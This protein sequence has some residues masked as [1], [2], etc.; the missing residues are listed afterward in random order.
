MTAFRDY[1]LR[2]VEQASAKRRCLLVAPMGAGKTAIA[3]GWA[4]KIAA[5]RTLILAPKRVARHT[6][7]SEAETWGADV[8]PAWGTADQ[9]ARAWDNAPP[10]SLIVSTHGVAGWWVDY[11]RGLGENDALILDESTAVKSSKSD[12]SRAIARL[13][14]RAGAV[15]AMTGSPTPGGLIDIWAQM[16]VVRPDLLGNK[17]AF[18]AEFFN[19]YQRPGIQWATYDPRPGACEAVAR[20]I[21]PAVITLRVQPADL[22]RVDVDLRVDLPSAVMRNYRQLARDGVVDE[23]T[24]SS[25]GVLSGKLRQYAQGRIYDDAR[26]IHEIHREK[27]NALGEVLDEADDNAIIAVAYRHDREIIARKH[28]TVDITATDAVK[29]WNARK[30]PALTMHPASG[31]HGLNL[32]SG[33]SIIIWYGLPWSLEH[34][35][36]ANAR[37][38]RFDQSRPVRVV[39]IIAAG[40]VDDLIVRALDARQDVQRAFVD[41]LSSLQGDQ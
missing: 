18:L 14:K 24:T 26:N 15:L 17:G 10:G 13:A 2:A 33:G 30:I 32:Q 4:R 40:T 39:R 12:R 29:N 36:Q 38:L 25:A 37:L 16:R 27:L 3:I 28:S 41:S 23:I 6:W 35:Q 31:S 11:L 19:V 1:Q 9:R 5:R 8:V 22:E 20:I 7:P 21:D 34:W